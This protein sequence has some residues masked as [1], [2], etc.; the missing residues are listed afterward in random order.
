VIY[1]RRRSSN[2]RRKSASRHHAPSQ[3]K[4]RRIEDEPQNESDQDQDEQEEKEEPED[5]LR[6]KSRPAFPKSLSLMQ[7]G[8][9]SRPTKCFIF[10]SNGKVV[11]NPN[12]TPH[13]H[14]FHGDPGRYIK[15]MLPK[16]KVRRTVD[17]TH[18]IRRLLSKSRRPSALKTTDLTS[19]AS[20]SARLCGRK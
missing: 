1:C 19:A 16:G 6:S 15:P 13:H 3:R 8:E 17:A 5:Q 18:Q 14:L 12:Q 7:K 9:F 10:C 11:R 20:T 2:C 4:P